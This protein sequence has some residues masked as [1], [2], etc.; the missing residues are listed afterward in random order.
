MPR[1]TETFSAES[2]SLPIPPSPQVINIAM[3]KTGLKRANAVHSIILSSVVGAPPQL[4]IPSSAIF[5]DDVSIIACAVMG[6]RL[7]IVEKE[8]L[9]RT[10]VTIHPCSRWHQLV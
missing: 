7:A 3:T 4:A 1:G 8:L 5:K 9:S 2:Q 6:L 10:L